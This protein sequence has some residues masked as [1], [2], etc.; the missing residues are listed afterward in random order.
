MASTGSLARPFCL[1]ITFS[2]APL[3]AKPTWLFHVC[4]VVHIIGYVTFSLCNRRW[5][6]LCACQVPAP[7]ASRHTQMHIFLSRTRKEMHISTSQPIKCYLFKLA[8]VALRRYW[9]NYTCAFIAGPS[10]LFCLC[11]WVHAWLRSSTY[12]CLA[13]HTRLF[14]YVDVGFF[15]LQLAVWP[16]LFDPSTTIPQ[17]SSMGHCRCRGCRR[18]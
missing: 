13:M 8:G 16:L 7:R 1:T 15:R 11:V 10:G 5:H 18:N 6:S 4:L 9:T 3:T 17:W 12:I 14:A 2:S